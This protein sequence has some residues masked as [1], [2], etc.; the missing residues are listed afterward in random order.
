[1]RRKKCYTMMFFS[2]IVQR[3]LLSKK[4]HTFLALDLV[5]A[6]HY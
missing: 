2:R 5:K 4:K 6:N 3:I 1:M